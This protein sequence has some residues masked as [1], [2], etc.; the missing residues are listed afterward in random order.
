MPKNA[1]SVKGKWFEKQCML[2]TL[3]TVMMS[4]IYHCHYL[5]MET[6]VIGEEA[7]F[8]KPPKN[9]EGLVLIKRTLEIM[10]L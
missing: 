6:A 3:T 1:K 7:P 2:G 5:G 4:Q 10:P 8:K 9:Q